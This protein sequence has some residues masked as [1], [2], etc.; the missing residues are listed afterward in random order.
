MRLQRKRYKKRLMMRQPVTT[1]DAAGQPTR[2]WTDVQEVA[3]NYR[4]VGGGEKLRGGAVVEPTVS[5]IIEMRWR[6]EHAPQAEWQ[7]ALVNPYG[8]DLRVWNVRRV[9]E[10]NDKELRLF[11]VE[12]E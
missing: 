2:G 7:M 8:D 9:M 5:T 6:Y 11:C 1:Q 12:A 3:C 4:D 10:L